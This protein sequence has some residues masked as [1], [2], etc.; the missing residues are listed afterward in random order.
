MLCYFHLKY[1]QNSSENQVNAHFPF[2]FSSLIVYIRLAMSTFHTITQA[3]L[4]SFQKLTQKKYRE[5]EKK[6]LVEGV[7]LVEEALESDWEIESLLICPVILKIKTEGIEH[8]AKGKGIEILELSDWEFEKLSDTVTSQ[9]IIAIVKAQKRS[10][11]ELL[12]NLPTQ[13]LLVA[14]EEIGDPGNV[15]TI[16][17]T[18]DWFGVQG[19]L[20]SNATVELYSPKV[21]RA[22]MGAIFHLPIIDD[23]D[24][25]AAL[26]TVRAAGFKVIATVSEE[27]STLSSYEFP[28]K[29][30]IVFGNEARGVSPEVKHGADGLLTI[31]KFG[32]AESL[33]V[34]IACGV[35]LSAVRIS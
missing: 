34:G 10:L 31:P 6:F 21:V 29:C 2:V 8:R 28:D 19:I 1:S 11:N 22:S 23:V 5:E 26:H 13:S 30:V 14:L 27:G 7:H 4:K 32:K 17:R 35:V 15:G 33:N 20:L 18:C 9:G 12:K 24:L 25:G 3:K 16:L